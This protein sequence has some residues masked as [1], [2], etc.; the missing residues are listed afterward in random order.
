[1]YLP[2]AKRLY[3][4]IQSMHLFDVFINKSLKHGPFLD[5]FVEMLKTKPFDEFKSLILG[6]CQNIRHFVKS[7]LS[8]NKSITETIDIIQRD[9]L[10]LLFGRVFN[11]K[12]ATEYNVKVISWIINYGHTQLL[13]EIVNH[14]EYSNLSISLVFG[15]DIME[16][17][18]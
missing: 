1:M 10:H 9:R 2:L 18:R 15:S 6:K 13:E 16:N 4:D 14:V 11:L 7:T 8:V 12:S 5:V 3:T 17:T